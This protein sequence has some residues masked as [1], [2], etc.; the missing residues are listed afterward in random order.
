MDSHLEPLNEIFFKF[1]I[2]NFLNMNTLKFLAALFILLL[3]IISSTSAHMEFEKPASRG[4]GESTMS[5]APCGGYNDT[6]A[7]LT[8]FPVTG[9]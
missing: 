4:H 9:K 3:G 5:E 8:D 2:K 7:S 6:S 1:F